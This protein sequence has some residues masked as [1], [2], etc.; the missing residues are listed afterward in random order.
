MISIVLPLWNKERYIAHT[1]KSIL[2][3]SFKEFELII[4]DDGSTDRS[5]EIV[6]S[7][8][9]TRIRLIRQ[10]NAGVSAARNRGIESA[11]FQH[12]AFIDGDDEWKSNH[13]ETLIRLIH[14]YPSCQIYSTSYLLQTPEGK[15]IEP[16]IALNRLPFQEEGIMCNFFEMAAGINSPLNMSTLAASK[17]LLQHI[18]GFPVGIYSGEDIITQTRLALQSHVAYSTRKTVVVQL[19]AEGRNERPITPNE[20]LDCMFDNLLHQ[21]EKRKDKRLR[22]FVSFWHK[23]QMVR[24]LNQRKYSLAWQHALRSLKL[25]PFQHKVF[26][27]ALIIL[28][29]QI[30]QSK[31]EK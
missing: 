15:L 27:A 8:E 9:D 6:Q 24:S 12:I 21:Q 29:K 19:G 1:V 22:H 5:V 11:H 28:R 7:F 20:P 2:G 26:A 31:P 25:R 23:Q 14:N 16:H 3:Q 30:F 18:G 10:A 13:L 4:V 17:E